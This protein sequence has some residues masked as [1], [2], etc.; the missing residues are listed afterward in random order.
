MNGKITSV[1]ATTHIDAHRT[2]I[3]VEGLESAAKRINDGDK[4]IF[5]INH[6]RTIP[7]SGKAV[8]AWV[9]L[10]DDGEHQLVVETEVFEERSEITLKNGMV[11]YHE[12]SE[13]DQNP[14]SDPNGEVSDGFEISYDP[15]NF[16][17]R[18]DADNFFT[19]LKLESE[20]SFT[21][22][23]F[24]RKSLIPDP[25]I[26]FKIPTAI[27]TFLLA[28]KLID[29]IGDTVI[30]EITKDIEGFYV[31]VKATISRTV[32]QI[33]PENRPIT[34]VFVLLGDPSFEFIAQTE[35][36]NLVISAVNLELIR[37]V[38]L[39]HQVV[40]NQLEAKRV[41]FLMNEAGEWE[42]NYLLTAKGSVIGSKKAYSR[43]AKKMELFVQEARKNNEQDG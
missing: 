25:E 18:E 22:K 42:F 38:I 37:E 15:V 3:T 13:T 21:T 36:P 14:F 17:S 30:N 34:Y 40:F 23:T 16:S 5:T 39:K 31:L 20:I 12:A 32:R 35:K 26:V 29:K 27:I 10:R 1:V 11:L 24:F 28:R 41:Q 6:D 19:E 9:E 2:K 43:R 33:R 4:A 8:K 7:P